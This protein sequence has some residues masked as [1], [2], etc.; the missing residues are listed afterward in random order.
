M[1]SNTKLI[2]LTILVYGIPILLWSII[3]F[4]KNL[5]GSFA[6]DFIFNYLFYGKITFTSLGIIFDLFFLYCIY[7]LFKKNVSI[8]KERVYLIASGVKKILKWIFLKN[9]KEGLQTTKEENVSLLF[10]AV[11]LFFTPVMT[12]F[13]IG[14]TS[15]LFGLFSTISMYYRTNPF[16]ITKI[17]LT[18]ILY[19]LIF[20]LILVLDTFIF[21][22]GYIFESPLLKNV[23]K[24]VEPTALGWLVALMCYPPTNDL[25]G[26][27]LG[28]YTN[29]FANFGNV[30]INII[31][32]FISLL[33]FGIYVWASVALGF[34]ASNLTNRGIVSSG[35]YKYIRH[36]AYASKNLSWWLMGI[37]LIRIYGFIAVLS[38]VLWSFIYFMRALTEERH[39][40]KDE[41][42]AEYMKK[43]KYLFIPGLF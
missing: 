34:K 32:G 16:Q 37:P 36:P 15:S 39:L 20:S 22:L 27:V 21:S 38:L 12:N 9:L 10:Y 33:L 30:N 11:K 7:L 23:V 8:E 29:D 2:A 35:P 13:L 26:K 25:T 43:T 4:S 6:S 42:Y 28:W 3:P 19:P 24:S 14:N 17:P 40:M 41:A 5:W 1:K 18:K 31:T